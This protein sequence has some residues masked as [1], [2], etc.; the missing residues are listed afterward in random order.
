MRQIQRISSLVLV[1][2]IIFLASC[3]ATRMG[4]T[5]RD[6]QGQVLRVTEDGPGAPRLEMEKDYDPALR[7]YVEQN[8]PPDYIYVESLRAT[9]L[10]FVEDDRII[11]FQRPKWDTKGAAVV[12]EGIPGPLSALFIKEDQERLAELRLLGS[13]DSTPTPDVSPAA[14]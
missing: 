4:S 7:N 5:L 8:G 12:T 3:T 6:Y 9:Q 1:I 14:P 2:G 11:R 10:I 13:R